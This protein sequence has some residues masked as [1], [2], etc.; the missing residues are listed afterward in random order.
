VSNNRPTRAWVCLGV[1][2]A[3]AACAHSRT[4]QASLDE[5]CPTDAPAVSVPSAARESLPQG[6][7]G[8]TTKENWARLAREIPGGFG[9]MI[10][11]DGSLLIYLVDTTQRTEATAALI[12]KQVLAGNVAPRIRAARWSF[13]QLYDWNRYIILHYP[14]PNPD[15]V[16]WTIDEQ[17]N[18]LAF[19]V[20]DESSRRRLVGAFRDLRLPCFLVD[21]QVTGPVVQQRAEHDSP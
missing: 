7:F 15:V 11:L 16:S 13:D 12:A 21:I 4:K 5:G 10:R 8:S 9:G 20:V 2:I 18:R 19:D 6:F 1:T 14:L 3:A 17:K